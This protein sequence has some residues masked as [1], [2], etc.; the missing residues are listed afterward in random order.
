[1]KRI[2]VLLTALFIYA[3][4]SAQSYVTSVEYQKVSRQ[5][6]INDIPFPEKTV[7]AA[8]DDTLQKLG[9]KGKELKGYTVYRG[10]KWSDFGN[11]PLDLYYLVDRKSKKEKETSTVTLILSKGFDDFITEQSHPGIFNKAKTHLDSL[12]NIIA[13][14]DLEQQIA[15]QEEV[16]RGN[17]KRRNNLVNDAEDLQKKKKKL[18][19][20][21]ENNS[22]EQADLKSDTEKQQQILETLKGKRRQ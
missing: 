1:M 21:I 10:V 13:Y 12:R 3:G 17:E 8:I 14:Y 15:E 19:K 11:E 16:M 4:V 5:A 9:Y 20:D 22:K 6:V 18:E 2:T 7:A